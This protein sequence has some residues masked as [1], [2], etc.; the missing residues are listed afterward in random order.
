M[1]IPRF[2]PTRLEALRSGLVENLACP[3]RRRLPRWVA[4]LTF[5]VAGAAAGGAVSAAAVGLRPVPQASPFTIGSPAGL[6]GV[7]ALPGTQPGTPI[8][9]LLGGGASL[10]VSTST[11]VPLSGIPAGASDVR[12]TVTCE[13]DGRVAWGT[14]P[15]GNNPSMGCTP[16]DVGTTSASSFYDFGVK[17]ADHAIYLDVTGEWIVSYQYLKKVETAWGVNSPGQTYGVEKPAA[18]SPDLLA[19]EGTSD[20]GTTVDGY[21]FAEQ[22]QGPMPTSPAEAKDFS[23]KLAQEYPDGIP[24]PVYKSDGTTRIGTFTITTH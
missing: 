19:V 24:V 12:V 16:T 23:K 3:P 2:D 5:A 18:G 1:T 21:A 22:L 8:V 11:T 14:D 10:E 17:G 6:K 4:I 20:D 9:S 15:S 7:P 13:T